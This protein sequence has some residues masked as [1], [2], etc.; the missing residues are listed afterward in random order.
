MRII[1]N[2]PL[3]NLTAT[4]PTEPNQVRNIKKLDID[5]LESEFPLFSYSVSADTFKNTPRVLLPYLKSNYR[6]IA[7][8]AKMKQ[9]QFLSNRVIKSKDGFQTI[10]YDDRVKR[11]INEDINYKNSFIEYSYDNIENCTP[12]FITL[13]LSGEYHME[14]KKE[15]NPLLQGLEGR[16]LEEGMGYLHYKGYQKIK[17]FYRKL[18]KNR[19]FKTGK[20]DKTNRSCITALEP[21][22]DW[23]AHEHQLHF[24]NRS[25]FEDFISA[26]VRTVV[27]CSLGRTQI[28][29]TEKDLNILKAKY[30]LKEK[31]VNRKVKGANKVF[32]EYH[33]NNTPIFF[34]LFEI[35]NDNELK[36]VSNYLSSYVE[37]KHLTFDDT[38]SKQHKKQVLDY[39]GFAYYLAHLKDIYEPKREYAKTHKKIRRINYT[40]QLISRTVYKRIMTNDFVEHLKEIGEY[41]EKN[42]YYFTT[43]MLQRNELKVYKFI[44]IF[45]YYDKVN[46]QT[47]EIKKAPKYEKHNV[48]YYNIEYKG[49][50]ELIDCKSYDIYVC[51]PDTN[52]MKLEHESKQIDL[53]KD[54]FIILEYKLK[55]NANKFELESV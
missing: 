47:G 31:L 40:Q 54:D 30:T 8:E 38:Q 6:T 49:Y 25:Y 26:V 11:D 34:Q 37:T 43:K 10:N 3:K 23:T 53:G 18:L 27:S 48:N 51:D 50:S 36:S 15:I 21:H 24:I 5:N 12:M 29:V 20:L 28:V 22:K 42:M 14:S 17:S 4:L 2:K 45:A 32:T 39:D 9:K 1:Q 19:L 46:K 55:R 13:T 41:H 44:E 35:S 33:L 7:K 16:E 52:E